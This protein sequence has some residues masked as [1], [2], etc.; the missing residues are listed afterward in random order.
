VEDDRMRSLVGRDI[1][2]K[3]E[4]TEEMFSPD[5]FTGPYRV[6][7]ENPW[8]LFVRGEEGLF[9]LSWPDLGILKIEEEH[10]RP[11]GGIISGLYREKGE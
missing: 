4:E 2:F 8:G 9:F 5:S 7:G 3:R 6:T 1:R 10:T 11:S